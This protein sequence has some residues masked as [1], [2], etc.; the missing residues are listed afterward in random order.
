MRRAQSGV[1]LQIKEEIMSDPK[2]AA[3][4][5]GQQEGVQPEFGL[6]KREYFALH[7]LAGNCAN[8]IPGSHHTPQEAVRDAVSLADELLAAL[9]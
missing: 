4:P 5:C 6:T 1:S 2:T 3:Y 9:S 8:S 7:L